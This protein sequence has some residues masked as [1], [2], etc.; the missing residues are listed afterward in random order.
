MNGF[1]EVQDRDELIRGRAAL[2][3]DPSKILHGD[4]VQD[5]GWIKEVERVSVFQD[6]TR[7]VVQ[8]VEGTPGDQCVVY[9][10]GRD[11]LVWRP[12]ADDSEATHSEGA[13]GE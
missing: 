5:Q 10:L 3:V 11:A 12:K 13:T 7:A 2:L 1:E 8:F 4:Y 9:V 6:E